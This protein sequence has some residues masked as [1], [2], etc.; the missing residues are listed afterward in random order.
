[1]CG[2]ANTRLSLKLLRET[3]PLPT[4]IGI[5]MSPRSLSRCLRAAVAALYL[6]PHTLAVQTDRKPEVNG[7]TTTS[8]IPITTAFPQQP[9]CSDQIWSY[10]PN[11]LAAWDPGYGISVM[12]KNCLP[13]AATTWWDAER[14][15]PNT[16][17][18]I[19]IGPITC[20]Q[21]YY[22]A[23]TSVKDGISTLVGCCPS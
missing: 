23:S 2:D 20:P 9:G 4:L 5:T 13:R 8:W 12:D 10:V 7:R 18:T 16:L 14:L 15:G 22:T 6:V 11:T 1:M 17:T 3:K 21:A 19:S